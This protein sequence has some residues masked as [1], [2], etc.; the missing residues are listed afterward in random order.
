MGAF[1]ITDK[2]WGNSLL[3]VVSKDSKYLPIQPDHVISKSCSNCLRM[4][5]S[6]GEPIELNSVMMSFFFLSFSA[7]KKI[8]PAHAPIHNTRTILII[9]YLKPFIPEN[10]ICICYISCINT[11]TQVVQLSYIKP[12]QSF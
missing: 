12:L 7:A 3:T 11:V 1:I 4:A 6:V 9:T 10:T 5:V 2:P 8:L